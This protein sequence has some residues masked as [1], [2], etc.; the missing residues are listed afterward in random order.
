LPPREGD[1]WRRLTEV[2][3]DHPFARVWDRLFVANLKQ[4][5]A[6]FN[7]TVESLDKAM[8]ETFPVESKKAGF[9]AFFNHFA[10]FNRSMFLYCAVILLVCFSWL[11][12]PRP[13]PPAAYWLC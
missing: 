6:T 12:L 3:Q 5:A 4:D 8:Q 10:P 13:L 9:E 1:C 2:R 7:A 11:G